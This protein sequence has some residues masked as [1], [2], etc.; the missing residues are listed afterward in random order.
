M[1]VWIHLFTMEQQRSSIATRLKQGVFTVLGTLFL[2]L[3]AVGVVVPFLPTTPFLL[4]SAACYLKGSARM[5]S[6]LLNNRLF[7]TYIRNYR[8]GKGM[9]PKAKAITLSLLWITVI[10][11]LIFFVPN[12]VYQ[13]IMVSVCAGV[14]IHL[15]RIPTCRPSPIEVA[16][17]KAEML[18]RQQKKDAKNL[19]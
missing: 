4:L 13:L 3:G 5:H 10:P 7:G 14:T 11:S 18:S 2:A 9:S 6:W 17:T 8:E 1:N 19:K 15:L 16:Q 12:L